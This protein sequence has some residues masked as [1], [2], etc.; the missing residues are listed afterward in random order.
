MDC[1]VEDYVFDDLNTTSNELIY[2]GINNLFGEITWFYCTSGSNIVDRAVTYS[3]LDSTAKRPIWFTNANA[4]FPRT[5][6]EQR[7]RLVTQP[8]KMICLSDSLLKKILM[9]M[10]QQQPIV[11]VHRDWPPDHG[12]LGLSLEEMQFTFGR[13]LLYLL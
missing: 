11:L 10:H 12:S 9:T 6:W 4:L 3:Y 2:A 1:L 13:I 7:Q 5:T 8:L